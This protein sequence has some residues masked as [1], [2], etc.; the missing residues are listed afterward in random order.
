VVVMVVVVVV[1]LMTWHVAIPRCCWAV[2]TEMLPL[3]VHQ[4][5][6]VRQLQQATL[7][8]VVMVVAVVGVL[9]VEASKMATHERVAG[10]QAA[11]A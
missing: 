11:R 1:A 5:T 10:V 7:V 6:E 4:M 9:L 8:V 3:L 2:R